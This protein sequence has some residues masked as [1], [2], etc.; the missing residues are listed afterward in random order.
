M[1][2]YTI[3]AKSQ[4]GG[5]AKALA[6]RTEI[7]FDASAGRD[8]HL[9]NPAELLLIALAACIL[10]NVERYSEI[11]HYLYKTARVTVS[12]LRSDHPP[13]MQ[14]IDYI[15]EIDTNVNERQLQNWH[16]NIIKFGTISNTIA[17]AAKLN[18]EITY[19]K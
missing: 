3:T 4:K 11:L 6:N 13:M 18:G 10:K 8:E 1:L 19:M 16:K 12:G 5:Q 14:E 7:S 9:P 2:N 15:L 17:R